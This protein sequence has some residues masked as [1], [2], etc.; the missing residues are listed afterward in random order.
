[1]SACDYISTNIL[2][3]LLWLQ[4]ELTVQSV[5]SQ[6][7]GKRL[8]WGCLAPQDFLFLLVLVRLKF[9]LFAA[10][11][12]SSSPSSSKEGSDLGTLMPKA[13]R[14]AII[15]WF[16]AVRLLIWLLCD[17]TADERH[18][19]CLV[20]GCPCF[21]LAARILSPLALALFQSYQIHAFCLAESSL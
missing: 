4:V 1:M 3:W 6:S 12:Q 19:A 13:T 9:L 14:A 18:L 17:F 8:P 11:L 20:D 2:I 10:V 16:W 21:F 7:M 15:F 5:W